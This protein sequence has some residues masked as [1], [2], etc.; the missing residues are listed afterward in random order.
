M[1]TIKE[2]S[3]DFSVVEQYL[4]TLDNN[5]TSMKD[6][7]DGKSIQVD[8]YILFEDEKDNGDVAEI[9]SII[10]PDKEVFSCQ[11][12]TFKRSVK[13]I[14]GI[15]NGAPFAVLKSSG[16]TKSGRDFINCALDVNSVK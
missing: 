7:E 9:L 12:V 5:I 6:V 8:G 10:T 11:S 1:I 16:V 4:M 3:R 14:Y 13:D 2:Q 15:M